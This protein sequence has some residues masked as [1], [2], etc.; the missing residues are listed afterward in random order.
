MEINPLLSIQ[1]TFHS[2]I[3][4]IDIFVDDRKLEIEIIDLATNYLWIGE[5]SINFIENL[6]HKAGSSKK[7]SIFLNM[8]ITALEGNSSSVIIDLES[9]DELEKIRN[10]PIL[11]NLNTIYLIL[12]YHAEFDKVYYPLPLTLKSDKQTSSNTMVS[13]LQKQIS[14]L[15]NSLNSVIK[16][17]DKLFEEN[18][19]IKSELESV[20]K[21]I[22]KE[23]QEKYKIKKEFDS[24]KSEKNRE[25]KILQQTVESL[26][27]KI[28][29][30][31][32]LRGEYNN[33]NTIDYITQEKIKMELQ[34]KV[35][36]AEVKN[37][38]SL[39]KKKKAKIIRQVKVMNLF[40][41]FRA[42][43]CFSTYW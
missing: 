43:I 2:K 36:I 40:I 27:R 18:T 16:E 1:K 25:I 5:F 41:E 20:N 31:E 22:D 24:L 12:T 19:R 28:N 42:V 8:L 7:F 9:H 17:K 26:Q 37:L 15:S 4:Q 29:S 30:K 14:E 23:I 39:N 6:T 21:S 11:G 38:K 32:G 10:K 33:F 34:N 35:L 13:F 3:Y